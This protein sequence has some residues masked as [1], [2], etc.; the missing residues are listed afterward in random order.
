[1]KITARGVRLEYRVPGARPVVA[2]DGID[3]DVRDNEFLALIGP[4]GCGKST[5]LYI[6]G[7]FVQPTSGEVRVDGRRVEAPGPERGMVFQHF[8]LFPWKTVLGNVLYGLEEQALPRPERLE[9]ARHYIG[10]VKLAGFEDVY[11]GR[12]S[13]GM[14]QRVALARTL[15]LR[16]SVLLMDEPFGALDAQTRHLM[17]EELREIWGREKTTVVFVTHDVQEALYLADRIA[18][19]TAAPGRIRDIV[20]GRT[21]TAAER[22]ERAQTIWAHVRE[23]VERQ[24]ASSR[25]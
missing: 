9:R 19:M 4:S 15:A 16:P 21:T 3:L 6:V 1:M 14:R 11:P 20:D 7:G 5:F 22:E 17:Q 8:A 13:G 25:S 18:V 10:L 2:L 12:L 24:S 23:E